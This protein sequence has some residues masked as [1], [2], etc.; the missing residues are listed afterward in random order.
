MGLLGIISQ[1]LLPL[2]LVLI[3]FQKMYCADIGSTRRFPSNPGPDCA[4]IF[5]GDLDQCGRGV[6]PHSIQPPSPGLALP[7]GQPIPQVQCLSKSFVTFSP[8]RT[9]PPPKPS[10]LSAT[11]CPPRGSTGC[12]GTAPPR[13]TCRTGGSGR[14]GGPSRRRR[15]GR[16]R[17]SSRSRRSRSARRTPGR[18]LGGRGARECR[19]S[20]RAPAGLK[21]LFFS[22]LVFRNRFFDL[23]IF[24]VIISALVTS[25]EVASAKS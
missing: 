17:G 14:A 25:F 4:I 15:S 3:L 13:Q 24:I 9:S 16:R 10:A 8:A 12:C 20:I 23:Q 11:R 1:P 21:L 5:A 6:P 19:E 18:A 7:E 2:A 22:S